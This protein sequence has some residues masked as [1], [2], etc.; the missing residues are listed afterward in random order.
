[1]WL[2]SQFR[3]D[4]PAGQGDF[5]FHL[6]R[7][8]RFLQSLGPADK[9]IAQWWLKGWTEEEARLF[10]V[11]G[12]DGSLQRAALEVLKG[13]YVGKEEGPKTMGLWNGRLEGLAPAA[14]SLG[15]DGISSSDDIDLTI[16]GFERSP[17]W[18]DNLQAQLQLVSALVRGYKPYYV[19]A[20]SRAYFSKAV[21]DDKPGVNWMLYLP[22]VLTAQQVPEA[23]ALVAVDD[24]RGRRL[25]TIVVSV[26]DEV[27]SA[28][29]PRHVE[30]ANH[31]EIRLVDQ[32]LLP[33][34]ADFRR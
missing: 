6:G 26:A 15:I 2:T 16:G 4:P 8:W 5:S 14:A 27:F 24:A 20:G 28:D 29:N 10:P 32:D 25:G 30:A 31:I 9:G 18:L 22:R 21:F 7:F 34:Y 13:R 23:A 17:P 33:R 1:M 3:D 11:F 19:M 12:H